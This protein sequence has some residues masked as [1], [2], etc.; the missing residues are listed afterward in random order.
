MLARSTSY[1]K[2]KL[3]IG[4]ILATWLKA[5]L[6]YSRIVAFLCQRAARILRAVVRGTP[7]AEAI[8]INCRRRGSKVSL[9]SDFEVYLRFPHSL[10]PH[11]SNLSAMPA[12]CEVDQRQG[13]H[14][15]LLAL[16]ISELCRTNPLISAVCAQAHLPSEPHTRRYGGCHNVCLRP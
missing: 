16:K 5:P 11:D 13:A 9:N 4:T 15:V 14:P 2:L 3:N 1:H 6:L 7:K 10:R 12:I 8:V